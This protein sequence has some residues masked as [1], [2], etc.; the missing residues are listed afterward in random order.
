MLFVTT[1]MCNYSIYTQ[2]LI[3][4]YL[5]FL[6][7]TDFIAKLDRR[8]EKSS[9]ASDVKTIKYKAFS[10]SVQPPSSTCFWVVKSS[11]VEQSSTPPSQHND[12][13]VTPTTSAVSRSRVLLFTSSSDDTS[14]CE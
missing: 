5:L 3:D 13:Q 10:T 7:L 4:I 14:D 12:V 8:I 6:E 11:D 1:C 2:F 9:K